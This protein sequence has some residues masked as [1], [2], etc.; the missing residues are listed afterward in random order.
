MMKMML[1]PPRTTLWPNGTGAARVVGI[2]RGGARPRQGRLSRWT[3]RS[4]PVLHLSAARGP[5][6]GW[7]GSGSGPGAACGSGGACRP[8][9]RSPRG[10][11]RR[12]TGGRRC[13]LAGCPRT[14]GRFR[15]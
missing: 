12:R 6:A 5:R 11:V 15:A 3:D 10:P 7:W 9:Q 13:R 1:A 8:G 2:N 14:S 4:D